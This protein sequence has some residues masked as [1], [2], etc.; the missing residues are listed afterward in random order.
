MFYGYHYSSLTVGFVIVNLFCPAAGAPSES[1]KHFGS[2]TQLYIE[3]DLAP[4]PPP[5]VD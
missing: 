1:V 2:Q 4:P 5:Q 3:A